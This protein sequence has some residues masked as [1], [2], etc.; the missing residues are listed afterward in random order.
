MEKVKD[1]ILYQVATDQN[2]KVGQKLKFDKKTANGQFNRVF[3]TAFKVD[4]ARLSDKMYEAAKKRFKK[5]KSKNEIY[6]IAH[7]LE[8]Y[9]VLVK[10]LA[11]EEVR[12]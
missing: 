2:Y 7:K 11:L 4:N 8:A 1:L 12:K 9:D 5:F 10:E 6:D 3:N